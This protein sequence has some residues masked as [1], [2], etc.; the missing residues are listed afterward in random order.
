MA[1]LVIAFLLVVILIMAALFV[2]IVFL[3]LALVFYGKKSK[4]ENAPAET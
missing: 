3:G 1:R 2:L 4:N